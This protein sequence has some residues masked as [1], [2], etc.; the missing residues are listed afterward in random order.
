MGAHAM[1]PVSGAEP[2]AANRG[3]L[4]LGRME[5][6]LGAAVIV[7]ALGMAGAAIWGGGRQALAVLAHVRPITVPA[8][9]A[10]SAAN[11]ATRALRW[12]LF[13]RALRLAVPPAE[14]ALIY[15]AGFAMTT[16]PGKM[17]EALRLY[18]MNRRYAVR[19][20]R[21][22]ALLVA[23]RLCDAAATTLVV[24]VSVIW[25]AQYRAVALL[26][27]AAVAG[28]V[29]IGMRPRLLLTALNAAYAL[30]RRAPRLFVRARRTVRGLG[31]L[32]TPGVFGPALALSVVGWL[33]EGIS[34]AL[35]LHSLG[36]ALH[37]LA[38]VF[39]FSFGMLVG[40]IS[41]LPGGLGSTEATMIGLLAA[42]GVPLSTAIVAT[43]IIRV[44]T[45][46][47][48]VLLGLAALPLALRRRRV[49]QALHA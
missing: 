1:A 30:L 41:V 18:V 40:A 43:G 37:P 9:L 26:G 29:T 6:A 35:L 46:W 27:A 23:D 12:L 20:D 42:Q 33:C 28:I 19:Y 21:S 10:L 2:G 8:L 48:A 22:A 5:W 15:V 4:R 7:F 34:F 38:C 14:N 36:V 11:Y 24:A 31:A 49:L 47:F 39:V 45:L 17:G 13:T 16:T 32:G 44:T 3:E 25:F